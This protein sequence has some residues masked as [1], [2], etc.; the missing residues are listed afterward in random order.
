MTET[1]DV[2]VDR[3]TADGERQRLGLDMVAMVAFETGC[4]CAGSR[5]ARDSDI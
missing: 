2:K 1:V 3:V 5:P 4:Q